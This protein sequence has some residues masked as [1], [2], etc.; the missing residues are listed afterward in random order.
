MMAISYHTNYQVTASAVAKL[1]ISSGIRRPTDDLDR[2]QKMLNKKN[3]TV[4]AW[5]GERLTGIGRA[6]TNYS[7]CCYLSDLAVDAEYQH[8]GIGT[9]IIKQINSIIGDE[10]MLLLLAAPDAMDYYP[11]IGFDAANNAWII[12]IGE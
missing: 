4:S 12:P 10:V 11:Y 1:F 8:Q 3:L 5:Y 2:I 6:L 9:E 7:F